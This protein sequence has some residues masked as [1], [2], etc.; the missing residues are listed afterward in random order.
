[1]HL[2]PVFLLLAVTLLV[3]LFLWRRSDDNRFR[4]AAAVVAVLLLLWFGW[5]FIR[6]ES[7]AEQVE[8]KLTEMAAAVKAKDLDGVFRHVSDDFRYGPVDKNRLRGIAQHQLTSGE[9]T[10]IKVWD[11]QKAQ[12]KEAQGNEKAAVTIQFQMKPVG[13]QI[14]QEIYFRCVARL[15]LDADGEWRVAGFDLYRMPGNQPFS[16]PQFPA[17]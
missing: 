3:L 12:L 2:S 4:N 14:P 1:M 11:F 15:V 13:P 7:A 6:K 9:L 17:R 16:P 10:E 8:R 5:Q